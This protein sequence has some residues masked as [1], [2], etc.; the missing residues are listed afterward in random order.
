MTVAPS[1]GVGRGQGIHQR[2]SRHHAR[3]GTGKKTM[4][5]CKP[6]VLALLPSR[7][8][9]SFVTVTTICPRVVVRGEV[10]VACGTGILVIPETLVTLATVVG[11]AQGPMQGTLVADLHSLLLVVLC[12]Q[13][14][15]VASVI[16]LD[17]GLNSVLTL[18]ADLM[19][20]S[21][22]RRHMW[23]HNHGNSLRYAAA[24]PAVALET[25]VI[26]F[27]FRVPGCNGPAASCTLSLQSLWEGRPLHERLQG[28]TSAPTS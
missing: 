15:C 28:N 16:S 14:T 2:P 1:F 23:L 5:P 8:P 22:L 17:T 18:F 3:V 20:A 7:P 24:S 19:V 25:A 13:T 26:L 11:L 10:A 4:S 27:A 6:H 21:H 12:P 9:Q